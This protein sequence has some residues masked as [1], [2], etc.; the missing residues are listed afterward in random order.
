ME[1]AG[2][3]LE[4]LAAR[5]ARAFIHGTERRRAALDRT[6]R[7]LDAVSY[8]AVLGRG[9]ALVRDETGAPLRAVADTKAGQTVSIE[10]ADG[11]IGAR[12]DGEPP[13]LVASTE[14]ADPADPPAPETATKRKR[15]KPQRADGGQGTLF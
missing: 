10:F 12:I 15:E 4:T 3:R 2:E 9:F 13:P 6:A 8:T 14:Q 1:T 7:L 11:R 5:S